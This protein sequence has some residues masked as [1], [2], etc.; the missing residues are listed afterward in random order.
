MPK[1]PTA[2]PTS[3]SHLIEDVDVLREHYGAPVQASIEKEIDYIHPVYRQ[4]IESSPFVV[5]ATSGHGGLDASPRGDKPGVV[6]VEDEKTLMI[7]DRPGNNRIDSLRN[8]LENPQVAL[9]FLVPGIG[10]SMRVNGRATISV[11]PALLARFTV[12]GKPPRAIIVVRVDTVFFQCSKAVVRADLWNPDKRLDRSALP[13]TG[14]IL[15][16][17]S[18]GRIN[19]KAYDAALP[20]RVRTMLY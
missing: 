6:V 7:P 4:F 16:E 14:T 9:F 18:K 3:D 19:A 11:D 13:S 17:V 20:E 2:M 5:V 8:I 10:E 1:G 15:A 12:N